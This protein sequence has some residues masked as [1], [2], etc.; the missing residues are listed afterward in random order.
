LVWQVVVHFCL[1][2]ACF[3]LYDPWPNI[4]QLHIF[5]MTKQNYIHSSLDL[6]FCLSFHIYNC[7]EHVLKHVIFYMHDIK[8][9]VGEIGLPI[10]KL[11]KS[12][13]LY[14]IIGQTKTRKILLTELETK[15][16]VNI[17]WHHVIQFFTQKMRRCHLF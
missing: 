11:S 4:N 15:H 13:S 3:G 8:I 16:N 12:T 1:R 17:L 10:R 6:V 7:V 2:Q 9:M 5:A 14:P